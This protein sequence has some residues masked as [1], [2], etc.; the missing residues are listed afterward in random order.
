MTDT[1]H[2]IQLR[3]TKD[4]D[5][6]EQDEGQEA[7]EKDEEQDD[8]NFDIPVVESNLLTEF[9]YKFDQSL[10]QP[11][12]GLL[13]KDLMILFDTETVYGR[14]T[15]FHKG[16]MVTAPCLLSRMNIINNLF[17]LKSVVCLLHAD[18]PATAAGTAT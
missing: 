2:H 3:Q 5:D 17:H 13:V 1:V 12:R 8:L 11:S 10:R 9:Q 15:A 6:D 7:E 14:R 16:L 4:E 18:H